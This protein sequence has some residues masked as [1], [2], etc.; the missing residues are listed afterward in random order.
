MG[1]AK[2][3]KSGIVVAN[4]KDHMAIAFALA[5][6]T[7]NSST[8]NLDSRPHYRIRLQVQYRLCASEHL[9]NMDCIVKDG[10]PQEEV[11]AAATGK[12]EVLFGWFGLV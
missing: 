4:A 5:V 3:F 7:L 9:S 12:A 8:S 11:A 2:Q 1:E 6:Q 10:T